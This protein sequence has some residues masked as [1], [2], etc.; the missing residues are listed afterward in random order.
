M[1]R[2]TEG[3]RRREAYRKRVHGWVEELVSP[4]RSPCRG[5]CFRGRPT[6]AN[7]SRRRE[8]EFPSTQRE[9]ERRRKKKERRESTHTY[10]REYTLHICVRTRRKRTYVQKKS[11]KRKRESEKQRGRQRDGPCVCTTRRVYQATSVV[12]A[13]VPTTSPAGRHPRSI[14]LSFSSSWPPWSPASR[15]VPFSP[16][17][18]TPR[19]PLSRLGAIPPTLYPLDLF[20]FSSPSS[21]RFCDT[22]L[23]FRPKSEDSEVSQ[24]TSSRSEICRRCRRKVRAW[25]SLGV[26]ARVRVQVLSGNTHATCCSD[27]IV[28]GYVTCVAVW[29]D[30]HHFY[31]RQASTARREMSFAND[32]YYVDLTTSADEP[33]Y[34]VATCSRCVRLARRIP[35]FISAIRVISRTRIGLSMQKRES[36]IK[37][38]DQVRLTS[39]KLQIKIPACRCFFRV[40]AYSYWFNFIDWFIK[41]K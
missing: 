14:R 25:S 39:S 35:K 34:N 27:V 22:R 11:R 5:V 33:S 7:E 18:E 8:R 38:L 31:E 9:R 24:C 15:R 10:V 41:G 28:D 40:I 36:P 2:R 19:Y 13:I 26:H 32:I 30:F 1:A 17:G 3:D 6:D 29:R 21:V 20:P 16:S 37:V 23:Y 12:T 4:S